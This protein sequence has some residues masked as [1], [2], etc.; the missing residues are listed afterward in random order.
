MWHYY[1]KLGNYSSALSS[2]S[3]TNL[4]YKKCPA[5]EV[6]GV[7]SQSHARCQFQKLFALFDRRISSCTHYTLT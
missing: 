1:S 7:S 3:V 4:V 2:T 6:S 5:E